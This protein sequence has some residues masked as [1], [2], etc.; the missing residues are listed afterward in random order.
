MKTDNGT[1]PGSI[2]AVL[3]GIGQVFF[4][5]NA[6][7]GALFVVG[8]ALG[9]PL[10]ALGAVAGS[11]IGWATARVLK[12]DE[13]EIRA[14]IY[15]FNSAL[16]G[17]ATLFFFKPGAVSF[18][19]LVVGCVAAAAL[20]RLMPA[21]SAVPD[22]HRSL[23]RHNLG[24]LFPGTGPGCGPDLSRAGRRWRPDLSRRRPT[25]SAR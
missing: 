19:L 24:G 7:T 4:Q 18:I 12:F 15:G 10:M 14:G 9:S 16:V 5:E 11:A 1:I 25:A 22:L 6:L 20:T 13:S 3:R 2:R 21:V 8:I 23:H 17:I